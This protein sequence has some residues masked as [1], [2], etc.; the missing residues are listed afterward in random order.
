[1]T[2]NIS[3]ARNSPSLCVFFLFFPF[4][5]L[6]VISWRLVQIKYCFSHCQFKFLESHVD[7]GK[8]CFCLQAKP[9]FAKVNTRHKEL[10]LTVGK[11][12]LNLYKSPNHHKKLTEVE[13]QE[14]STQRGTVLCNSC[15]LSH[16]LFSF[17]FL[18]FTFLIFSFI[19]SATV[20]ACLRRDRRD[21]K[22]KQA[23]HMLK[24]TQSQKCC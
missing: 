24:P 5:K 2:G 18:P 7:F 1:M 22:M 8:P 14:K 11:G 6:F 19:F 17:F 13:K 20:F 23:R 15:V 12:V 3:I 9:W 10:E 4:R 21:K 16:I